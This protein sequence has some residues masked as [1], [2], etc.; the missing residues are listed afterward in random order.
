MAR[1]RRTL[2]APRLEVL[3][4]IDVVFLLITFFIYALV[5]MKRMELLP[6]E[7]PELTA[8]T[9]AEA[10]QQLVVTIDADGQLFVGTEP[11][12]GIDDLILRLRERRLEQPEGPVYLAAAREGSTDRLPVFMDLLDRLRYAGLGDVA[13]MGS[14]PRSSAEPAQSPIDE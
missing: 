8:G 1:L 12:S 13:V 3:P 5:L 11:A 9:P 14:P 7:M 10:S 4:L 6:V 2:E